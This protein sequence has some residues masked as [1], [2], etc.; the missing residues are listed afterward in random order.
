MTIGSWDDFVIALE[1]RWPVWYQYKLQL[2]FADTVHTKLQLARFG[3]TL[4]QTDNR[5]TGD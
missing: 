3:V 5:S 2:R 1:T 4:P